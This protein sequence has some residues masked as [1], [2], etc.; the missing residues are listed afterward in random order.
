[1]KQPFFTHGLDIR[2]FDGVSIDGFRGT[3]APGNRDAFPVF[4][5]NGKGLDSRLPA[6]VMHMENVRKG[7]IVE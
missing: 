6:A 1:V 3:G 5:Q 7:R 2:E 4:L